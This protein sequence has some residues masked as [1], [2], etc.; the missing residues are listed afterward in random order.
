M[1]AK[2]R[3]LRNVGLLEYF[4]LLAQPA[5]LLTV[6]ETHA[7]AYVNPALHGIIHSTAEYLSLE[8]SPLAD[9][10]LVDDPIQFED[11]ID[12][13]RANGSSPHP[14]TA[15][16]K[17]KSSQRSVQ[18]EWDAVWMKPHFLALTGK[19]VNLIPARP[20]NDGAPVERLVAGGGIMGDLLRELDWTNS[21]LGPIALWPQS[22]R[23]AVSLVLA[24]PLPM[25]IWWGP[26]FVLLYN[27]AYIPIAA[28]K[29]PWLFGKPGAV[30]WSD[31]WDKIKVAAEQAMAGKGKHV[32]DD[33]FFM[34]RNGFTEETY[35][36]W[37]YVPI[38]Q[39]DGSIGG[40]LNPAIETT[41]QAISE[42]RMRALRDFSVNAGQAKTV[43]ELLSTTTSIL[44][45]CDKEVSFA[46]LYTGTSETSGIS[47]ISLDS[48]QPFLLQLA[49]TVGIHRGHPAAVDHVVLDL[50]QNF[51]LP[52]VWPFHEACT[53]R[54][55]VV[56]RNQTY[57]AGIPGRCFGDPSNV[58]VV[59]PIAGSEAEDIQ[60]VLVLGLSSRLAYND[61]YA[62]F[63]TLLH[64]QF[65]GSM[66]SII[67]F[68]EEVRRADAL[69]AIDRAKTAFFNSVSHELRTPLTLMLGPLEDLR[70]SKKEPPSKFQMEHLTL[71]SRNAKRLLKLVNSILDFSRLEAGRM[72]ASFKRTDIA[73][74]TRDLASNFRSAITKGGV[75]FDVQC[76][77]KS[78]KV[79]VDHDMWEKIVFNL[80]GNAFKFTT[81]GSI[82]VRVENNN[83]RSAVI[84]SVTDTGVGIPGEHLD[85]VFERFHR[86]EGRGGRSH[87]GTGI[88]LA[89][90]QE[91]IKLHG[92]ALWVESTVGK[93]STFFAKIP[94]GNA[95][96]PPEMIFEEPVNPDSTLT[97]L[98]Y[99]QAVVD[100]ANLW[101]P[102][103]DE[104]TMDSSLSDSSL[105]VSSGSG[106]LPVMTR[107][108]RVLLADDNADMRW[109]VRSILKNIWTVTEVADGMEALESIRAD[110]P[111]IIVSDVMMPRLDGIALV[112]LLKSNPEFKRIPIILLSARA[113]EEAR[114]DGL[115]LGAD[116]Y[117]VKPFSAKELRARVHAHLEVSRLRME[118]EKRVQERTKELA[119]SEWRYK[120]IS[121]LNPVG[122][123]KTTNVGHL[124]YT[125]EMWWHITMHDRVSDPSGRK[126][127][128]S[129]HPDDREIAT[130]EW[131]SALTLPR[132]TFEVRFYNAT[133][134]K[135]TCV[136]AETNL[137]YDD[138][139]NSVGMIGSFTDLTERKRLEK[140]RLA[141]LEIAETYQRRRAEEAE[142]M[143]RHQ[144]LFIDMT[145]HELRNPLN[146]IYHNADLLSELLQKVDGHASVLQKAW[147]SPG[148][149]PLSLGDIR[150]E[151]AEGLE[152]VE[153]IL[154]CA[155][156]Q[157]NIA[158]DVLQV[159]KISMN[160]VQLSAV[161]YQP[162]VE[163]QKAIRMYET[164]ARLKEI[165]LALVV[166]PEYTR[167]G[168]D[169][170]RGDPKR[171]MQILINLI[172]NAIRFTQRANERRITLR[173]DASSAPPFLVEKEAESPMKKTVSSDELDSSTIVGRLEKDVRNAL[174][175]RP[176][177]PTVYICVDVCDSG[178]GMTAEEQ[179]L[180]F[181]RFSLPSLKTYGEYGGTGLGLFISKKLVELQGGH[182]QVDSAKDVGTTFKFYIKAEL[183]AAA[184]GPI[185]PPQI[186]LARAKSSSAISSPSA[187]PSKGNVFPPPKAPLVKGNSGS[188]MVVEDNVVNQKVLKKQL[189]TA[190]YA[191]QIANHG[192]EA[193]ELFGQHISSPFDIILM[194]IE[195]PI[196]DGLQATTAIRK[197]ESSQSVSSLDHTPSRVPIVAISGNARTEYQQKALAVGMDDFVVKPYIKKDLL[198]KIEQLIQSRK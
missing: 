150:T 105:S 157:N 2:S 28:A 121:R 122:I 95:H 162:H 90:T 103:R 41:R 149:T 13:V 66:S 48:G 10:L 78:K 187:T 77:E 109:Y 49:A 144:E 97:P 30:G 25:S 102:D 73:A 101:I 130:N 58:V 60:G 116:D 69:A 115:E 159:S 75:R 17:I 71:V 96:L 85:R 79:Y 131:Q 63:I 57:V 70:S 106:A 123:F 82:T 163:I 190:G 134:N 80:I 191:V 38:R 138:H 56:M 52:Q 117:L 171:L 188:V 108:C 185:T 128:D 139:G 136:L 100:D 198:A 11:W 50:A 74:F 94:V 19:P 186:T 5:L 68:E 27:D 143:K 14:F 61:D 112:K 120:T 141:A 72:Q 179:T 83:D 148:T 113:G 15:Y 153:T 26:E 47:Q 172:S 160:L 118:L 22:L 40:L 110:P 65:A 193:L 53:K 137:E 165:D 92:G 168:V 44:T 181:G 175:G 119:E 98:R 145:C 34:S 196:M 129:I 32:E 192:A 114:V 152:A 67:A 54:S 24:S 89:L 37:A 125:N 35:F 184:E 146:G 3:P 29:H 127:L 7:I 20:D 183:R 155:R 36:N 107:G 4:D 46:L 156:H 6:G 81:A 104:E 87:E 147:T 39:E 132:H 59:C 18:I 31:I 111:D 173:L 21:P 51:E 8:N 135:E 189:E 23:T 62:T 180:L 42:R 177:K 99:G 158:D 170:V 142:R 124:I 76:N 84:F 194:D 164:E 93:G 176:P 86:V 45:S 133:L 182:I 195:M 16:A 151:V 167:L 126:F 43:S 161:D 197:S 33:L 91:L 166:K 64:R 88:G 174:H 55:V 140:E 1:F 9:L 178:L 12:F 169:W 154:Q